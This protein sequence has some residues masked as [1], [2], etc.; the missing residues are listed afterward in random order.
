M[1]TFTNSDIQ[2]THQSH[3]W[4]HFFRIKIF[5]G[6]F[7]I[8]CNGNPLRWHLNS[9]KIY[10]ENVSYW[11]TDCEKS[12][13]V[14]TQHFSH[15]HCQ[16]GYTC[17]YMCALVIWMRH[18]LK[19]KIITLS[20]KDQILFEIQIKIVS[21]NTFAKFDLHAKLKLYLDGYALDKIPLHCEYN[22]HASDIFQ[23]FCHSYL[24]SLLLLFDLFF[25]E[26]L[27]VTQRN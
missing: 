10:T 8:V 11:K 13:L 27:R 17:E 16:V 7:C 9:L 1:A 4:N 3:F 20:F 15:S 22:P 25:F 23:V 2:C 26:A 6:A 12:D 14:R 21:W 18:K 24:I 5:L 19:K